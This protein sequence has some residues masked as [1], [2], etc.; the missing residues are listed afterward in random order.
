MRKTYDTRQ[1][2]RF[3]GIYDRNPRVFGL[4][5]YLRI[6]RRAQLKPLT[7][8]ANGMRGYWQRRAEIAREQKKVPMSRVRRGS[9]LPRHGM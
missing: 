8:F 4:F 3:G 6:H 2:R 5:G 7:R 1:T 9:P